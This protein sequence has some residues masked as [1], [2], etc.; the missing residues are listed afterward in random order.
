MK[1]TKNNTA[2]VVGGGIA[3][4]LS[5][6]LLKASY[7]KVILV[8]QGSLL[9]G[10][11]QS[12]K[13]EHGDWFDCGTHFMGDTGIEELDSLLYGQIVDDTWNKYQYFHS[14]SYFSGTLNEA[15]SLVNVNGL[16]RKEFC[17]A[18]IQMLTRKASNKKF[19]NLEEQLVDT[20]GEKFVQVLFKPAMQKLYGVP[21]KEL[22]VDAHILFGLGR[23]TGF[24]SETT[25]QLKMSP[26][27]NEKLNNYFASDNP[28]S[29]FGYYPKTGGINQWTNKFIKLIKD[30][31]V[32]IHTNTTVEK[33]TSEGNSVTEAVLTDGTRIDLDHIVWTV[34]TAFALKA[35]NIPFKSN[36]P[37]MRITYVIN[38]V[39]DKPFL[40]NT[41]W[42]Q[43]YDPAVSSFRGTF[44]SNVQGEL[45]PGRFPCTMEIVSGKTYS[46]GEAIEAAKADLV[47]IG[48]VSP[49]YRCIYANFSPVKQGFPVLRQ[50][51]VKDINT[52]RNLLEEKFTNI[53][54]LGKSSGKSFFM[55]D[56]LKEVWETLK[57]KHKTKATAGV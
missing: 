17:E 33:L 24:D 48:L 36:R 57:T 5:A 31:G 26:V 7:R 40:S 14:S 52:Q 38:L 54:C 4:L 1:E 45:N 39:Y 43:I 25:E 49:D 28:S 29:K 27:Y 51:F 3:G 20:F 21:L 2:L 13:N 41:H 22:A 55:I 56:V 6:Y 42:C 16:P 37:D 44:Y 12:V 8:E 15:N 34:P 32:V 30:S 47:K 35:A 53:T 9:G 50:S 10:L 19:D 11:L 18:M 23:I 46:E